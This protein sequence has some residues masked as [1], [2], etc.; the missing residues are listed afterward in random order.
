LRSCAACCCF[1]LVC[2]VGLFANV[3]VAFSVYDQEPIWW[4]AGGGGRADG[5]GMGITPM[6]GCSSGA[7]DKVL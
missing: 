4:L 1:N 3:G 6:S 2:S 5:R 7:S